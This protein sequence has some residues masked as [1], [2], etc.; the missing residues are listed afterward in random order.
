[1]VWIDQPAG[2][3]FSP[4]PPSVNNEIDVANQF[5]DFWKNFIDAFDLQ[6]R[7]VYLTG[8]SYAGQHIPYIANDMLNRNDSTYYNLKGVQ[9]NDP[10]INE[11]DTLFQAPAV[12][13]LNHWSNVFSLNETF[14]T[15]I[16]QRADTCGYTEFMNNALIFPPSDKIPTAPD[17][18]IRGCDVWNDIVA[19]AFSID[20]CFNIY[21]LT[22]FCPYLWN[23]SKFPSR[24]IGPTN[25]FNRSDVQA[26]I[27]AP[28]T[29]YLNCGQYKFLE[30]DGS[31]PSGLG[32][33]PSVIERTNNVI[34]GHGVLDYLLLANG[35]LIT[36]QNMTWVVRRQKQSRPWLTQPI[37]AGTAPK[38]FKPHPQI[39]SSFLIREVCNS[40]V[41]VL[42]T[43][44]SI[45]VLVPV[46]WVQLIQREG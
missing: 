33:L 35:S 7:K 1:M 4:G 17:S 19:A 32:P 2:T 10:S 26:A 45:K 27:H 23:V 25:F 43:L 9:I 38:A 11:D 44:Q 29:N 42:H 34:I 28:S 36:I 39:H 31:P 3:G 41:W 8:E 5:N 37:T 18:S 14:M 30:P 16:N 24:T 40:S 13:A 21:H 6:G 20:P 15:S 46:Y 12:A 22:D